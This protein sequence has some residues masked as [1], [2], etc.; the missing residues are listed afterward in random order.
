M[1]VHG[2]PGNA[3]LA[4]EHVEAAEAA[5]V[6]RDRGRV[7]AV[8]VQHHEDRCDRAVLGGG[9]GEIEAVR[10]AI[11]IVA[12]VDGDSTAFTVDLER[13]LQWQPV[14]H[15]R[16]RVELSC[17]VDAPGRQGTDRLRGAVLP[18]V[19]PGVDERV[20]ANGAVLLE[21]LVEATLRDAARRDHREVVAVPDLRH[22]DAPHAHADDVLDV[23]EV[24]LHA[25]AGEDQRTFRVDVFRVRA[26]RRRHRVPDVGLVRFHD[27]GEAVLTVEEH[28]D[29]NR[30]VGGVRVAVVRVVVQ[31]RVAFGEVGVQ[32]AHH[33]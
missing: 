3:V 25:D 19:E 27:A 4:H 1:R 8:R 13:H 20:H 22:A 10:R 15:A 32:R 2:D 18:V 28:G 6:Q 16:E 14:G 30:V 17:R 5:R 24:P 9:L 7:A 29:E 31:E 33:V 26:V 21:Q 23:G 11:G 12:E